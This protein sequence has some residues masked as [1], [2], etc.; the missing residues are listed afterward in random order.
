MHGMREH[1]PE[2]KEYRAIVMAV[3]VTK[4]MMSSIRKAAPI[5]RKTVWVDCHGS[6]NRSVLQMPVFIVTLYRD[7]VK[8][9]TLCHRQDMSIFFGAIASRKT[10]ILHLIRRPVTG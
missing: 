3:K 1:G 2:Y 6:R 7:G 4:M 10:N 8:R 9:I 5:A